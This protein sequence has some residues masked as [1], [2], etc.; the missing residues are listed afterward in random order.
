VEAL[1]KSLDDTGDKERTII[2]L[3]LV[4]SISLSLRAALD[5]RLDAVREVFG[6]FIVRE[7]GL[8]AV[9]DDSDFSDLG[10]SGFADATVQR[11]RKQIAAGGPESAT[12]RSALMLLVRLAREAA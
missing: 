10:F 12:A 4:G 8:L 3:N 5:G 11:L 2:R 1:G 9:P 7:E 6:A